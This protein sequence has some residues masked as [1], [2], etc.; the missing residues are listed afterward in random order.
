VTLKRRCSS[1]KITSR[2]MLGNRHGDRQKPSNRSTGEPDTR[3][4]CKSGSEG[5]GWKRDAAGSP[6]LLGIRS[7]EPQHKPYL[8]SRPPY[9]TDFE[10]TPI[11]PT[12]AIQDHLSES[13][14]R[15]IRPT[16]APRPTS[17]N[18]RTD[19]FYAFFGFSSWK[20]PAKSWNFFCRTSLA[21]SRSSSMNFPKCSTIDLVTLWGFIR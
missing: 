18:V 12:I 1:L 7:H 17:D 15:S 11:R 3:K 5:G 9:R 16:G 20:L 14:L 4:R 19:T 13:R 2:S 21:G 10:V 8:A 6:S